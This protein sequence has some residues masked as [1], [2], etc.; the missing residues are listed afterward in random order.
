MGNP[1]WG[2]GMGWMGDLY[3]YFMGGRRAAVLFFVG[4]GISRPRVLFSTLNDISGCIRE[5]TPFGNRAHLRAACISRSGQTTTAGAEA[6]SKSTCHL[7]NRPDQSHFYGTSD[8]T[9]I[10]VR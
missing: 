1:E 3:I 2:M 7:K 10:P 4:Y 6:A 5:S 8:K 9:P